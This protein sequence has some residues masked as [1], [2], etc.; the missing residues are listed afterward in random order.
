MESLFAFTNTTF[1][2]KV[3]PDVQNIFTGKVYTLM[4]WIALTAEAQ[5]VIRDENGVPVEWTLLRIGDNLLCQ[6]GR[7]G[8][9]SLTAE[10]MS[11]ILDYHRK[12]GE[13][14]PLD[15][16]HYL[17]ELANQKKLDEHETLKMFPGGVAALG[18]GSLAL[19]GE[20]LRVKV[21]WTPAAYEF[22]KEKIYKY[23]SPV[24]RGLENGPLRVT[25]VAMT[26]TP[27]INHLDALAAS[28]NKRPATGRKE[29]MSK[30]ENALKRLLGRDSI[31]LG[32]ETEEK[33]K[34]QIA[35]EVEEKASL[36]EQVKKLLGL[37]PEAT[38]DEVIAA[39]KAETEKAAG[40]DEK[41]EKLDE[42]AASAE[43]REHERLVAQGRAEGK[44]SDAD[45][46]YVNSL[47]SKAL[48]AHLAHTARKIPL[49][50]TPA[51]SRKPDSVALSAVDRVAIDSLRNAGV[52]DAETEYL[53]RKGK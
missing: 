52:K 22:M 28:A 33:E 53:K 4:D 5:R 13:L 41:Q 24:I 8:N 18:Y 19:S 42:L 29:S 27:A 21:K 35:C 46:E 44:I 30:L 2:G 39:L 1:P 26:N 31:A 43:K 48:S 12:K 23:F 25:S 16:E 10:Q 47:D 14:I 11:S 6:E 45:M 3:K 32:A 34:D 38:L 7:D 37:A 17:Y 36:I 51:P 40:A 15:S 49:Q 20:E 50:R 9:L